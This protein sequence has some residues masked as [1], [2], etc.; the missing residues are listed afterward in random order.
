M[1]NATI[2]QVSERI[3]AEAVSESLLRMSIKT[4]DG[5]VC[6]RSLIAVMEEEIARLKLECDTLLDD[7][8]Q[9]QKEVSTR[10]SMYS[11]V[12]VPLN[13]RIYTQTKEY[14]A[15]F[16]CVET[17]KKQLKHVELETPFTMQPKGKGFYYKKS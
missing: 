1:S 17:A 4:G 2:K 7:R 10:D 16:G 11:V 13:E 14:R 15:A 6:V 9:D 12:R 3:Y 5:A 8:Y